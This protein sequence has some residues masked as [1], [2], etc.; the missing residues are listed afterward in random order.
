MKR[1]A[2]KQNA[3]GG[4]RPSATRGVGKGTHRGKRPTPGWKG[5]PPTAIGWRNPRTPSVPATLDIDLPEYYTAAALIGVISS[6]IQEPDQ[7]WCRDWSFM[8]GDKMA[9]ES[10][11]RRRK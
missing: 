4:K 3:A 10:R 8:M 11:K 6:Q 2:A 5:H 9:R 7:N 1:R